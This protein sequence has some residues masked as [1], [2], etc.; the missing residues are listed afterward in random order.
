MHSEIHVSH[1]ILPSVQIQSAA[2]VRP[3]VPSAYVVENQISIDRRVKLNLRLL[4]LQERKR[5]NKLGHTFK[6]QLYGTSNI[7]SFQK[8]V[9]MCVICLAKLS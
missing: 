2:L 8:K 3:A 6:K 4:Q 7:V 5:F 9:C 1:H